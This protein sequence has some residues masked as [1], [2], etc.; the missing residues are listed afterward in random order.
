[1]AAGTVPAGGGGLKRALVLAAVSLLVMSCADG[2]YQGI[3]L[4]PAAAPA[5][6][7]SLAQ[8]ARGGDK[9]AQLELGIRFEEGLGVPIDWGR[10]ERLYRMAATAS[11]GTT[12]IYVPPM[13]RGESGRVMPLRSGPRIPGLPEAQLRLDALRKRREVEGSPRRI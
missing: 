7:Q 10:A 11:G 5:E 3:S 8:R 9:R 2:D 6:L 12:M 13:R 1:M 4:A